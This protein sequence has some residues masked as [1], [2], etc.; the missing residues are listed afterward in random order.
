[1][2]ATAKDFCAICWIDGKRTPSIA[3]EG[4]PICRECIADAMSTRAHLPKCPLSDLQSCAA[5]VQS[6]PAPKPFAGNF[7]HDAAVTIER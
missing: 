7:M 5:P 4:A 3:W 1:M 2:A 6:Q